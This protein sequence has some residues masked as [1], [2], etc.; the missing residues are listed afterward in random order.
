MKSIRL[1]IAIAL[2][3]LTFTCLPSANAAT[4][5]AAAQTAVTSMQPGT[6]QDAASSNLC[7]PFDFADCRDPR[8]TNA[9]EMPKLT[10][11]LAAAFLAFLGY[12]AI[13]RRHAFDHQA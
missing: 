12:L 5:S 2:L 9:P 8:P 3:A 7:A 1:I 4:S 13:R 10:G 11:K 6:P